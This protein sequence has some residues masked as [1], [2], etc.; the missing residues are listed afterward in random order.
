MTKSLAII[1]ASLAITLVGCQQRT[2]RVTSDPPGAMLHLNDVEV[3]RTPVEVGFTWFGTYAVKL[4]LEGYETLET[5][6]EAKAPLHEQPGFDLIAMMLPGEERTEIA[7]HFELSPE[8][9]D[10]DALIGRAAELRHDYSSA[11]EPELG[12]PATDSVTDSKNN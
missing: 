1:T 9:R 7:W 6:A 8:R 11:D 10:P 2:L 3:G 4:R 12:D 5:A